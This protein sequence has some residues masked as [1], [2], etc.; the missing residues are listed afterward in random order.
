MKKMILAALVIGS[1]FVAAC[2]KKSAPAKPTTPP[3]TAPAGSDAA[4]A[5]NGSGS[6]APAEG[7][8]KKE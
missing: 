1:M 3:T 8:D 7:G 6:A 5:G 4:P 2:S